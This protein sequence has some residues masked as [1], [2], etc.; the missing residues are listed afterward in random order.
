MTLHDHNVTFHPTRSI[1]NPLIEPWWCKVPKIM[2]EVLHLKFTLTPLNERG[3]CTVPSDRSPGAEPEAEPS[4]G[5]APS[6]SSQ[7]E[8]EPEG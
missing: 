7:P 4:Y 8:P 3:P 2:R 6:Y 1:L 5:R